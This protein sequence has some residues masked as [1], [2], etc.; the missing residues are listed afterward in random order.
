MITNSTSVSFLYNKIPLVTPALTPTV[1]HNPILVLCLPHDCHSMV[2][3]RFQTVPVCFNYEKFTFTVIFYL[4]H[5]TCVYHRSH[6]ISHHQFVLNRLAITWW[7][8]AQRADWVFGGICII[9]DLF[10]ALVGMPTLRPVRITFLC[11]KPNVSCVLK[12]TCHV[13]KGTAIGVWI[14]IGT[15]NK[16]LLRQFNFFTSL[17]GNLILN[18]CG[19]GKA[20]T[21][22]ALPLVSRLVK[23]RTW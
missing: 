6:R 11:N 21:W 20:V 10:V 12:P 3:I 8:G 19:D 7:K 14:G 17:F 13:S 9:E 23:Q 15:I 18:S 1:P 4:T 16:F 5:L 2:R 22:S